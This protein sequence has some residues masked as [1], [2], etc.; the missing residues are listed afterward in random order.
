MRRQSGRAY[1]YV[2]RNTVFKWYTAATGG[3]AFFTGAS[4]TTP[5][6]NATTTYYVSAARTA[7]PMNRNGQKLRLQ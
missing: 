1:G 6:L 7:V 2:S 4:Y 3:T 5:V